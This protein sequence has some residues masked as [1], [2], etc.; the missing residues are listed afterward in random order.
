MVALLMAVITTYSSVKLFYIFLY[1]W[2]SIRY[3]LSYYTES[4]RVSDRRNFWC[5]LLLSSNTWMHSLKLVFV[6]L[7][8]ETLPFKWTWFY[9]RDEIHESW[10]YILLSCSFSSLNTGDAPCMLVT[11]FCI[12]LV[13]L[14][15]EL[16]TIA[17]PV[18]EGRNNLWGKTKEA[19]KHIHRNYNGTYDWV[20]KADDDT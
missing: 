15:E 5:G 9:Y 20:L 2:A 6:R 14:D 17:L 12:K 11:L 1:T 16:P 3:P 7:L 4:S 13:C 10:L 8:G 19:F 18:G